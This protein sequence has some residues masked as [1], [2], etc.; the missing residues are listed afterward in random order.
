[1][2]LNLKSS[3]LVVGQA[4]I[5]DVLL[6][7]GD[8]KVSLRGIVNIGFILENLEDIMEYQEEALKNGEIELSASGNSTIYNGVHIEYYE[9]VLNNLTLTTR[10]SILAVLGDTL[11]GLLDYNNSSIVDTLRILTGKI[12]N[13]TL[14]N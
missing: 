5:Q 1:M 6:R 13:T 4:T 7:P 14:S 9:R 3:D 8:N 11:Q 2:T 12:G 10:V